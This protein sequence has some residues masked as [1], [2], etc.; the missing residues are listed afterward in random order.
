MKKQITL[1]IDEDVLAWFKSQGKGYQGKMNDAL[2]NWMRG[3]TEVDCAIPTVTHPIATKIP[4]S[5]TTAT[6]PDNFFRPMLK[7]GKAKK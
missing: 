4:K 2:R 6:P 1:R 7:T 3:I 5:V